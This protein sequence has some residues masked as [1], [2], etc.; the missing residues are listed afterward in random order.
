MKI[1]LKGDLN[2]KWEADVEGV[3]EAVVDG[4]IMRFCFATASIA[5]L[6]RRGSLLWEDCLAFLRSITASSAFSSS[7]LCGL[8][9]P[10][11]E[12]PFLEADDRL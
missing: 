5:Q 4:G 2:D 10:D 6:G 8:C 7:S 11:L 3:E 12:S 1:H 9:C